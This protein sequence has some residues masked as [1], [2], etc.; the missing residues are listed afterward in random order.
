VKNTPKETS[1]KQEAEKGSA[2]AKPKLVKPVAYKGG[3]IMPGEVDVERLG[4]ELAEERRRR[5]EDVLSL[6]VDD[7]DP[8]TLLPKVG[9]IRAE[10]LIKS[11]REGRERRGKS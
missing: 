1:R 10:S 6:D 5:D 7:V 9:R 8:K 11:I 4:K 2:A 3:W